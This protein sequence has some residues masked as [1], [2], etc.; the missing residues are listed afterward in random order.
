[1]GVLPMKRVQCGLTAGIAIAG[2]SAIAFA[3][4]APPTTAAK[5]ATIPV[6]LTA[7]YHQEPPELLALSA[8]RVI[9]GLALAPLSPLIAAV[10]LAGSDEELLYAALR[11]SI[12]APL[13]A[14]DPALEA[15]A[16]ILP[17][18][19]GGGTG[20]ESTNGD[21]DGALLQFRNE[22]LWAATNDIRSAIADAL[23]VDADQDENPAAV[24]AEGF[25]ASA[26][27][28]AS[29]AVL[30]PL[31]LIPLAQAIAAG[32]EENLYRAIR[33]YIDAPLWIADP[34][35]EAVAQVLPDSL[36][37]GSDGIPSETADDGAFMQIRND[38]LWRATERTRTLVANALDVNPNLDA[39]DNAS[40]A[41]L[42]ATEERTNVSSKELRQRLSAVDREASAADADADADAD[43]QSA[44][45][46]NRQRPIR[47][48]VKSLNKQVKSASARIDRAV[49]KL[50][51]PKHKEDRS[52]G[53][54]D[55]DKPKAEKPTE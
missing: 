27:N 19:L 46:P 16:Q 51:K 31:G 2:A 44:D 15:I 47:A 39:S 52:G 38:V 42:A 21:D 37:G 25:V 12:D 9:G 17:D 32:D 30:A 13:W 29:G 48:A 40:T 41:R 45:K 8:Q 20:G 54:G 23:D 6:A 24:L 11:Q 10:A 22:V 5:T 3:P 55:N 49:D 1:M 36:G 7:A 18:E 33:Q 53:S 35:I 50:T 43:D 14:V 34:A 26:T 4:I 28:L